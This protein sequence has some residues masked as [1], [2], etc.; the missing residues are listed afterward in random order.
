MNKKGSVKFVASDGTFGFV[1]FDDGTEDA[2]FRIGDFVGPFPCAGDMERPVD[3]DLVEGDKGLRAI[4]LTLLDSR[5]SDLPAWVNPGALGRALALWASFPRPF[6]QPY[7]KKE[8]SSA[9]DRLNELAL[10]EPWYFG[11]AL[12]PTNPYPIL[13]NYLQYTFVRLCKQD[14]KLRLSGTEAYLRIS[15]D[16]NW[17]AFNTGLVDNLYDPVYALFQ[18]NRTGIPQ[19]WSLFD[20]CAAGQGR[21]GSDLTGVFNPLPKRPKYFTSSLDMLLD[22][23][24]PITIKAE[25]VIVDG[26][27]SD[28]F[29]F[30]FLRQNFEPRPPRGFRWEDYS[31][32]DP[33]KRKA[34]LKA[35][36]DAA[37]KDPQAQRSIKNRLED[38]KDLAVK[39]T[40]W[41]YKTAIPQYYARADEMSLLLPM[42]LVNDEKVD[43]SLVVSK[44]ASNAYEAETVYPL[45]WAYQN[46]RLVCRP[47]SDWLV[48]GKMSGDTSDDELADDSARKTTDDSWSQFIM[49]HT[50]GDLVE[51]EVQ[52]LVDFGAFVH[53]AEGV[54]GLLHVS[55]ISDEFT[56]HP[57]D[58]L[59]LRER[60]TVRIM[61]IDKQ[62]H[63]IVL[64][65]RDVNVKE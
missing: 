21:A 55:K 19:P 60:V 5:D 63:K 56:G 35:L 48:P 25:H 45:K 27:K 36:A 50:V 65:L 44:Q 9:L 57:S 32:Y 6:I 7:T 28:R 3:C 26:I 43:T 29:P 41:N 51:G 49:T 14:I 24:Q 61:E 1:E 22:T 20:F 12:P 11:T 64:S 39:R 17:A 31:R 42:C 23:I 53:L 4:S 34:Y 40:V 52:N 15:D 62:A 54:T 38:A 47:D 10:D 30:E 58:K 33:P 46:A 37:K 16:G 59:A 8:Y 2:H 18:K 13:L